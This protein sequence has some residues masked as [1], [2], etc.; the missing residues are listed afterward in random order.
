MAAAAGNA[1]RIG[2]CGLW[3]KIV[4]VGGSENCPVAVS[5]TNGFVRVQCPQTG[6]TRGP[7]NRR[8]NLMRNGAGPARKLRMNAQRSGACRRIIESVRSVNPR[9]LALAA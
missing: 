3:A 6:A 7:G 9:G 4:S 8:L 1:A 5:P 2:G